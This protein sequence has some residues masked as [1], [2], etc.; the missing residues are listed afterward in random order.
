M[1]FASRSFWAAQQLHQSPLHFSLPATSVRIALVHN[2]GA[3]RQVYAGDDLVHLLRDAGYEVDYFQRKG[4]G[5][6][7]AIRSRPQVLVSAGGDGTI[8][9]A[10]IALRGSPIPLFILPTGTSNNIA[11]AV[12][13]DAAIPVLIA[14][15]ANV[16]ETRL[17]LGHIV[18]DGH[19]KWFVEGAG[20]GFIAT[21]LREDGHRWRHI[22]RNIRNRFP[23]GGDPSTRS[24]RAVA[25]RVRRGRA[26]YVR[27]VADGHD[28]SGEYVTVEVMNIPAVGPR[29]LLAKRADPSDARLELVLVRTNDRVALADHIESLQTTA[30][31]INTRSV[32]R[33]ELDWPDVATHVDDEVWPRD[34]RHPPHRVSIEVAGSVSLLLP[35]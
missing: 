3:G 6:Q 26:R 28:L 23:G 19:E 30:P 5:V 7:R 13:L 2:Q 31:P 33:I 8:A 9:E 15:L 35:R 20:M 4:G 22:W 27:V 12:G 10:A 34:S 32:R 24:H 1:R 25:A 14:Q 17:D 11:R 21:M 18:G 16:R 29:I